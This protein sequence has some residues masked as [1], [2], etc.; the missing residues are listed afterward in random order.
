M[1]TSRLSDRRRAR[2][3]SR[4]ERVVVRVGRRA[5]QEIAAG[6]REREDVLEGAMTSEAVDAKKRGKK[7]EGKRAMFCMAEAP[8]TQVAHACSTSVPTRQNA[9]KLNKDRPK[10]SPALAHRTVREAAS[11]SFSLSKVCFVF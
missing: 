9:T 3:A 1:S 10:L 8:R 5:A 7:S 4:K 6:V 2:G 11:A